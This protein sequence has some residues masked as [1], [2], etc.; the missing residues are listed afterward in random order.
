MSDPDAPETAD[1]LQADYVRIAHR[2]KGWLGRRLGWLRHK[3]LL[4]ICVG[5]ALTGVSM[6]A[7]VAHL[8]LPWLVAVG[9]AI[10]AVAAFATRALEATK[11]KDKVRNLWPA[12]QLNELSSNTAWVW[13]FV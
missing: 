11:N 9:C 13:G 1:T 7:G 12:L 8:S 10:T 6:I 5:I 3:D 4:V 2:L